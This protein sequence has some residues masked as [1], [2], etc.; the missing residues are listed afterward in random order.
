MDKVIP[1]NKG[2]HRQPS[3][4]EAGELSECVNLIPV[5]GELV[6][7]RGLEDTGILLGDGDLYIGSIR[8]N[9]DYDVHIATKDKQIK[10]VLTDKDATAIS[11]EKGYN[12]F[13]TTFPIEKCTIFG[14]CVVYYA[15]HA[16]YLLLSEGRFISFDDIIEDIEISFGLQSKEEESKEY[17]REYTIAGDNDFSFE[18]PYKTEAGN[19]ASSFLSSIEKQGKFVGSF[20]VRY[21]YRMFDNSIKYHS[22]P[23]LMPC[24]NKYGVIGLRIVAKHGGYTKVTIGTIYKC[25]S[26]ELYYTCLNPSASNLIKDYVRAVEV[27]VC[28][29]VFTRNVKGKYIGSSDLEKY[30]S[31]SSSDINFQPFTKRTIDKSVTSSYYDESEIIVHWDEDKTMKEIEQCGPFFRYATMPFPNCYV[32]GAFTKVPSKDLSLLTETMTENYNEN[33]KTEASVVFSYNNRV[34]RANIKKTL[35]SM[36]PLMKHVGCSYDATG[37]IERDT[38]KVILVTKKNGEEQY[39]Y[40]GDYELR[41]E[42]YIP[43]LFVPYKNV[44]RMILCKGSEW[45]TIPFET[46][47]FQYGSYAFDKTLGLLSK[48]TDPVSYTSVVLS[49]NL[50]NTLQLS[51]VNQPFIYEPVNE[52]AVGSGSIL[53][54][55]TASKAIS[56]GQFGQFPLYVFCTDG[57]WALEVASDGTFSSKQPVSRD[58]CNNPDSITQID[59]AVVFTTDQGL[60]IIRGGDTYLLSEVMDGYNIPEQDYF[61]KGFFAQHGIGEFDDLISNEPRDMRDILKT[62]TIAYD[63]TNELLRIFPKRKD[64][65]DATIPY[66]YYVYSIRTQEFSSVVS[67]EFKMTY[68]IEVEPEPDPDEG[69]GDGYDDEYLEDGESEKE[70]D[71]IITEQYTEYIDVKAVIPNYPSSYIQIGDKLYRPMETEREGVQNGLLLTRPLLFDEP[72]ALK[73]MHDLRLQYSNFSGD[74]KCKVVVYVSND[75]V[76]W[77]IARSLRGGAN[78]YFRIAVIT[79]MTDADALTGAIVRYELERTNKL[80]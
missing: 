17:A 50:S 28:P 10:Y 16:S 20:F 68:E 9:S 14:N 33:F 40:M 22:A 21:A 46:S 53:G 64:D 54:I 69:Y 74:S 26:H 11:F 27:Y 18:E 38:Y 71:E 6:N 78:K 65:S 76:H 51:N 12:V 2:I 30:Y 23:V 13:D 44:S 77:K 39:T 66:K 4:G 37:T 73:K 70:E 35:L 59:D 61:D 43:Y 24:C 7:V 60:K 79:K 52:I 15:P 42:A 8:T 29:I 45:Y 62:C 56:Q 47:V 58:V 63:Y 19:D 72:F 25:Y 36:Y 3:L 57:I 34:I 1:F 5:N 31:Y 49:E 32:G 48:T 75:G 41:K 80:R 55:S 67:D